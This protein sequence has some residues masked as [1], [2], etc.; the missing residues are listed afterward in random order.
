M[1]NPYYIL[2]FIIFTATTGLLSGQHSPEIALSND[3]KYLISNASQAHTLI[4]RD[5]KTQQTLKSIPVIDKTGKT[6][7]ITSIHNASKRNSFIVGLRDSPEMWEINYQNPPPTGFGTWVHDYRKDSGE[8]AVTPFPIRRLALDSPLDDFFFDKE[9]VNVISVPCEGNVVIID[10]DLGRKVAEIDLSALPS[11]DKKNYDVLGLS[12]ELLTEI[13]L[14]AIQFR[15]T[16][17]TQPTTN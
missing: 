9:Y 14:R 10:L 17:C 4:I 13:A 12:K 5:T 1:R 2:F 11:N 7:R 8:A 6:S 15:H 3:N 16:K